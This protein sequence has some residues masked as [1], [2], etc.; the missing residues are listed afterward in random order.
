MANV[1]HHSNES[2]S[3]KCER[4]WRR[5]RGDNDIERLLLELQFGRRAIHDLDGYF[6]SVGLSPA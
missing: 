5:H 3:V 2:C 6:E 4:F 1:F